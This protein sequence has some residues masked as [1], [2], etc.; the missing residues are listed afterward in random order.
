M[1]LEEVAEDQPGPY[2]LRGGAPH[3]TLPQG[4][5][6][7]DPACAKVTLK[8]HP[9]GASRCH[10]DLQ[11][12]FGHRPCLLFSASSKHSHVLPAARLAAQPVLQWEAQ[13]GSPE[14][15]FEVSS[16]C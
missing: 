8:P 7:V 6:D 4:D 14:E 11:A 15:V 10:P 9:L 16:L 13:V 3:P 5:A 2:T 1:P 12:A